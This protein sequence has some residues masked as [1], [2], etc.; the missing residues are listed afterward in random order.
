MTGLTVGQSVGGESAL[1]V[2]DQ[3][4]VLPRGE[5]IALL[6]GG[7]DACDLGQWRRRKGEYLGTTPSLN[8]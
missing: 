3:R 1:F 6:G 2:A 4:Q 5:Q 8:P 7:Q